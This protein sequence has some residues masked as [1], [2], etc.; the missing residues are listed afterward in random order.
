MAEK[1]AFDTFSAA[2]LGIGT[3]VGIGIFIV[4]G[5]AGSIAGNLVWLSFVIGGIIAL[6]SGYSLAKLAIRFPSRGG[7]IE[8]LVQE[9]GEGYFSGA[10]SVMFYF[11]QL[12]TLAAVAK[13]FGEYGARLFGHHSL[14][15]INSFAVGIVLFFTA[16]NLM[17]ATFVAKSENLIVAIKLIALSVFTI[18]A[19]IHINPQYLSLKDAPPVINAV[20]AIGLTFFAY[21]GYSVITNAVEDME[22]PKRTVI[23]A[24]FLAIGVVTV[25]Y[26]AVSIAV[27]GNLP[28]SEVIK[29][30]DYA[31][32]EAAK[33]VFGELG[34]KIM[35]IVA[36]I[37]A[38]SAINATLYAA[39]EI[40]YTLAK[41]GELPKVYEYNVFNSYEGLLISTALI[42]P[43]ILFFNLSE[44]TTVAALS[45]LIIQALVHYGHIKLT[46]K[47]GAKKSVIVAAFLLMTFVVFATLYYNA[48]KDIKIIY[49]L[50][51]G[52]IIAF[53]MEFILRKVFKRTVKKQI[54]GLTGELLQK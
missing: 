52:F 36:L 40:S 29:A 6:L 23:R 19:L 5:L 13:S 10:L 20:F 22:D 16:I 28:L 11:A 3:M 47:T 49:Y 35:A 4:I 50:I 9:F 43:M 25:L 18:A 14:F 7:I 33:P 27:L 48:Q 26:V 8:Y 24:M 54:K 21:Q 15:W 41:K 30:K 32:A 38:T 44:I 37:S 1:K 46:P 31:L 42:I 51:G 17:G 53:I 12:V 45:V 34:F 39:T 2:M